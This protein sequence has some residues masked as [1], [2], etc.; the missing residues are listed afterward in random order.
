MTVKRTLKTLYI[1]FALLVLVCGYQLTKT[2]HLRTEK[3]DKMGQETNL[4]TSLYMHSLIETYAEKHN[5][6]KYILF[7]VA[8]LE[9]GY[10]GPFHVNYNP[11]LSILIP[12]QEEEY[13][14][15]N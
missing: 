9:T 3:V 13:R 8:Y 6:P 10:R 12:T 11:S 1:T 14:S 2:Q 5:I 7:N 4:P 15:Q